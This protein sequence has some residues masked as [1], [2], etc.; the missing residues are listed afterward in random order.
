MLRR[1]SR[2]GPARSTCTEGLTAD[3]HARHWPGRVYTESSA[4]GQLGE[5]RVKRVNGSAVL[6]SNSGRPESTPENGPSSDISA[7]ARAAA[8]E[9]R[10]KHRDSHLAKART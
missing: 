7:H 10:R 6:H 5:E 3:Q 1:T 4:G 9:H 2:M 8:R